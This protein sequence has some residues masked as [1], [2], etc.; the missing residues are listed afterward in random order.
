MYFEHDT[1][2]RVLEAVK[3]DLSD[4]PNANFKLISASTALHMPP[5]ST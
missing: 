3:W 4:L 2:P 5:P 1:Y